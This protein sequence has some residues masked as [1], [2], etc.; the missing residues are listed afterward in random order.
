MSADYF[1]NLKITIKQNETIRMWASCASD[2]RR[3]QPGK[4]THGPGVME[5]S[6][7]TWSTQNSAGDGGPRRKANLAV[8][9]AFY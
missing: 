8:A 3:A 1:A 2:T 9:L 7:P 4:C 5:S 6:S